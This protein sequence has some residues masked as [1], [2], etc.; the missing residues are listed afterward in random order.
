ME[1]KVIVFLEKDGERTEVEVLKRFKK[2]RESVWLKE[3]TP[4]PPQ[5]Q[6]QERDEDSA[7]EEENPTPVDDDATV[8][9]PGMQQD[10]PEEVEAM[11]KMWLIEKVTELEKE[12]GELKR[13]LQEK[14]TKTLFKR[15]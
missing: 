11:N 1:E 3:K 12:N 6:N 8:V 5:V 7:T 2:G 14:E 13:V 4:Q 10:T 15:R 9:E